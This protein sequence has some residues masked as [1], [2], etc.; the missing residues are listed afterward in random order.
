ML[1]Q[2]ANASRQGLLGLNPVD[3]IVHRL[4]VVVDPRLEL[5]AFV[6]WLSDY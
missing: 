3:K 4:G 2:L 5:L 1:K 6:Q